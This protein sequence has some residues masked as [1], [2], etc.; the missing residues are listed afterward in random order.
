MTTA[1]RWSLA[2]GTAALLL[3][4][5]CTGDAATP[6]APR[7]PGVPQSGRFQLVAFDSCADALAGLKKAG[8]ASV[9]PWGFGGGAIAVDGFMAGGVAPQP[10]ARAAADSAAAPP[11]YSG[12]NTHEVGVDEPDLIKTDG[13][14]IVTIHHGVLKVVDAATRAV[15]G[16]LDIADGED[17]PARWAQSQLLLHGDRALVLM[18]DYSY[19]YHRGP[20]GFAGDRVGVGGSPRPDEVMGPKLM[21]VDLSGAPRII[22]SFR[23]DGSL[24]DARQVGQSARVVVRSAPRLEFPMPQGEDKRSDKQ[25]LTDNRKVIS[26]ST[27]EE[28]LPRYESD[29]G[30]TVDKGLI[31][32]GNVSRPASYS[33]TS[34]LTV[35]S[36]DLAGADLGDGLPTTIVADGDTVYSN[37]PS[38]YVASDQRWRIESWG[39]D[40]RGFRPADQSTDIYRFDTSQPGRPQFL[41]SGSVPGWLVNQYA[42][43]EWDGHLRVA[44]TSGMPWGDEAKSSSAVYVLRTRDDALVRT[45]EVGGLG[46]GERIYSVRFA[47]TVGYVVTFRQVDPL[48]TIDLSDPSAPR[49]VGEL[50]ITGYSAYLHPTE[51]GRLIG[52]GQEASSQGRTQGTQ[53]SLFDVSDLAKPGRLAQHHVK[54]GHSEAEFD[55]HA[56]LYWPADRLLV[57]PLVSYAPNG[58][59]NG[60][61]MVLRVSDNSF[62]EVGLVQHPQSR[63]VDLARDNSIRRSLMIDR[64][65]W[66]VSDAGLRATN[67]ATMTSLSWIAF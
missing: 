55:P 59:T 52:I 18:P 62:T 42:M 26:K 31:D 44:T 53:V 20:I 48:Y 16:S 34:M 63:D 39:F 65:L 17:D 61:A 46:K 8:T 12:T 22:S 9:G 13:R 32:C 66:T 4:A 47:G 50:K 56:F 54:Q 41:A 38:L 35:L 11:A 24:V 43:S 3:L 23:I 37:G 10:A 60:G 6:T 64:T 49:K 14:R 27:V 1:R 51:P 19:A 58:S 67:L 2:A 7:D 29:T 57:V 40:R 5:G 21:L 15:T 30:G 36:F 28:W 45:G 33:G 25:R